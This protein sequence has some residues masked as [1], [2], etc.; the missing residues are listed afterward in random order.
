MTKLAVKK[1]VKKVKEVKRE[2]PVEVPVEAS[3]EASV[4]VPVEAPVESQE[5]LKECLKVRF[6]RLVEA[7][8]V[9]INVLREEIKELRR[10][11]KEHDQEVRELSKKTKKKRVRKEGEPKRLSGL[12]KPIE[13]SQEL[14]KFLEPY[15][16]KSGDLVSRTD[17]SRMV[18]R[19]IKENNLQYSENRREI[20]PDAKLKKI[21]GE[22]IEYRVSGDE[23][24]PRVYTY[25]KLQRYLSRHFPKKQEA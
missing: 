15:G 16:V 7:K 3:V 25:L 5:E 9:Q 17:V 21:L 4:E 2:V 20:V 19:Y 8:T 23:T 12:A 14:A 22:S 1:T 11:Q 18:N 10:M 6:E 13:I 24:S